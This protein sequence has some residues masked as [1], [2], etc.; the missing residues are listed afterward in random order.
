MKYFSFLFSTSGTCIKE[1]STVFECEA[2]GISFVFR[3]TENVMRVQCEDFHVSNCAVIL[4][5]CNSGFFFQFKLPINE[6]YSTSDIHLSL[7][8]LFTP[9]T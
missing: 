6:K 5:I 1:G 3:V 2:L 4:L 7:H 9:N 8:Y